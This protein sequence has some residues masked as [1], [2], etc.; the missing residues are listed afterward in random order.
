MVTKGPLESPN[1]PFLEN[2]E[3]CPQENICK[4]FI[5]GGNII[6]FE[7]G[8]GRSSCCGPIVFSSS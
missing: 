6:K 4:I 8:L 5:F 1:G 3:T 2:A 7:L